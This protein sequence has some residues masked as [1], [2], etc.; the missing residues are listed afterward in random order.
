MSAHVGGMGRVWM[1][2]FGKHN[3][4]FVGGVFDRSPRPFGYA[5]PLPFLDPGHAIL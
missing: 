1:P 5:V 4:R 2:L 3:L